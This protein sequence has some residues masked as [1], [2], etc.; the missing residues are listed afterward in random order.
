M[1]NSSPIRVN[2]YLQ[3]NNQAWQLAQ[4]ICQSATKSN[5]QNTSSIE[6]PHSQIQGQASQQIQLNGY[7]FQGHTSII[8]NGNYQHQLHHQ[9]V[10][11]SESPQRPQQQI[12]NNQII[13][14]EALGVQKDNPNQIFSFHHQNGYFKKKNYSAAVKRNLSQQVSQQLFNCELKGINPQ[15]NIFCDQNKGS[16]LRSSSNHVNPYI[17]QKINGF[18]QSVLQNK[19]LYYGSNASNSLLSSQP[20]KIDIFARSTYYVRPLQELVQLNSGKRILDPQSYANAENINQLEQPEK[21]LIQEIECNQQETNTSLNIDDSSKHNQRNLS[22]NEGKIQKEIIGLQNQSF[23]IHCDNPNKRLSDSITIQAP[24]SS[25]NYDFQQEDYKL[26]RVTLNPVYKTEQNIERLEPIENGD[27]FT[28]Q[29]SNLEQK[30]SKKI[31]NFPDQMQ[32]SET[33]RQIKQAELFR[34]SSPLKYIK[35]NAQFKLRSIS[36][37][38]PALKNVLQVQESPIKQIYQERE[39]IVKQSITNT[40]FAN[41]PLM[42]TSSIEK[43]ID[44]QPNNNIQ[45]EKERIISKSYSAVKKSLAERTSRSQNPHE[46]LNRTQN[47]IQM[48]QS[49]NSYN[50]NYG[51]IRKS[52]NH[53]SFTKKQKEEKIEQIIL[54]CTDKTYFDPAGDMRNELQQQQQKVSTLNKNDFKVGINSEKASPKSQTV[55]QKYGINQSE[56]KEGDQAKKVFVFKKNINKNE[57]DDDDEEKNQNNSDSDSSKDLDVD[58][59]EDE[60]EDENDLEDSIDQALINSAYEPSTECSASFQPPVLQPNRY[61]K[62]LLL[63]SVYENRPLTVFFPYPPQCGDIIRNSSR[64]VVATDYEEKRFDMRFKVTTNSLNRCVGHAFQYAGIRETED[65]DWNMVWSTG[66]DNRVKNMIKYQKI[67]HFPQYWNMGRKD[68]LWK[69]LSKV[70]RKF[71]QEYDFIPNT[72]ILQHQSDWDRFLAKRD[73]AE[74]GKLWIMKPSNQAQGKN[75]KM[76]SKRSKVQRKQEYIICEYVAN[77]HLIDGL[78]YDLRIYVL[79]TSYDPL[80]I[81]IFDDGLTRFATEK[82]STNTKELSKR[83][84]HLTNY[85]LNKNNPNFKKN[86]DAN[87]DSEGSKWSLKALFRKYTEMGVNT[88]QL[89]DRIKDIV[90]K[91]CIATEPYMTDQYVKCENH[92]TNCFE[93]YGFDILID[94]TLK[95]WLLEVNVRPS[96]SSSS[97]LDRRIKHTL[98]C[99]TFNLIGIQPYDKRK[100]EEDQRKKIPGVSDQKRGFSKNLKDLSDLNE[101]N[102]LQK[103]SP[104]DWN[105]LFE[106]DE[107]NYRTG[108]FERIF[109]PPKDKIDFYLKFFEYERYNNIIIRSWVKSSTNFLEKILK[110]VYEFNV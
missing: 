59:D 67:N 30:K 66:R 18:Q 71:P 44:F 78:K 97:P 14:L 94:D 22:I 39:V 57:E 35:S 49:Q 69:N 79:V 37:Q 103:L 48:Y 10:A 1:N 8:S 31:Q 74:K 3:S 92:R 88:A 9:K 107:E 53:Y 89:W 28:P 32:F 50:S 86:K 6:R 47:V 93:L 106:T 96:L 46:I 12:I 101:F 75:I 45:D 15:H 62:L 38:D 55:I 80:R 7:N 13:K 95:P 73:D 104:E 40:N 108:H 60:D 4:Q 33:K 43:T 42:V 83:Y 51:S 85:S 61:N 84:V 105:M 98:V 65:N 27:Q 21:A 29:S 63:K 99:D 2:S 109:P 100:F 81:Y 52:K 68:C 41:N 16:H 26:Q 82:Y 90:I 70:K 24:F 87:E 64:T 58:S 23:G 54:K 19:T 25:H 17:Q 36:Q 72:Y 91:T 20:Q 11:I 102:C 76:I 56:Q 34:I 5:Q 77:P 110:K